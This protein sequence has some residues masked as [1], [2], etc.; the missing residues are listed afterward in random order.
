MIS[1]DDLDPKFKKL[2]PRNFDTMS[3]PE[4]EEYIQHLKNEI[5]RAEADMSKK[6]KHKSALDSFFKPAD[7]T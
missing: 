7:S 6:E 4:L 3:I 2:K 1:D 5:I